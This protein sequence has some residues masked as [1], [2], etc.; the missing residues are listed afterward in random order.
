MKINLKK[1]KDYIDEKITNVKNTYQPKT[2]T[3]A[4]SKNVVT[5][6]NGKI[7]TEDKLTGSSTNSDIKISNYIAN[8]G[9]S[10]NF[11]KADHIHPTIRETI[12]SP[13]EG[14]PLSLDTYVDAGLYKI[15]NR[16]HTLTYNTENPSNENTLDMSNYSYGILE[17]KNY[18][19]ASLIQIIYL[20]KNNTDSPKIYYRKRYSKWSNWEQITNTNDINDVKTYVDNKISSTLTGISQGT[21]GA[22]EHTA[23][24]VKDSNANTYTNISSSLSNTSTQ[25]DINSAINT[26]ISSL[27]NIDLVKIVT[28]TNLPTASASTMNQL[29][30][31]T[32]TDGTTNDAYNIYV[33]VKNGSTY[34]WEKI[35]DFDLQLPTI[36]STVANNANHLITSKAVYDYA[37]PTLERGTYNSGDLNDT[38]FMQ[39][40]RYKLNCATADA[41]NNLPY[42]LKNLTNLYCTLEVR[43]Y[44]NNYMTQTL[45]AIKNDAKFP[46][47]FYRKK[48]G[49]SSDWDSEWREV[50]ENDGEIINASDTVNKQYLRLFRLQCLPTTSS[51]N[52]TIHLTF[53]LIDFK[54]GKSHAKIHITVRYTKTVTKPIISILECSDLTLL[55]NIY[56]CK[57]HDATNG[58]YIDIFLKLTTIT[59]LYTKIIDKNTPTGEIIQ[60][61][62]IKDG[63]ESYTW[64]N[65]N[66]YITDLNNAGATISNTSSFAYTEIKQGEYN[67]FVNK[68]SVDSGTSSQFLKA[69]G[70]ID[71]NDYIKTSSTS[72][73]IKND[74]TIGTPTNTTYSA[75]TNLYLNGTQFNHAASGVGTISNGL[76]KITIDTQGHITLA[77]P[78]TIDTAAANHANNLITSQAVYNGLNG[79]STVSVSP[80][81]T[82]GIEIGKITVDGTTKT[83]YQQDNNTT[84]TA[85]DGLKLSSGVFS[86]NP[87][88]TR[89]VHGTD[90]TNLSDITT[91]GWYN[92]GSDNS[93]L[94][95]DSP[96]TTAV[97]FALEVKRNNDT[98]NNYITQIIYTTP[99]TNT[100]PNAIYFRKISTSGSGTIGTNKSDWKQISTTD[101]THTISDLNPTTK[102]LLVYYTDGSNDT[103]NVVTK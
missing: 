61:K 37:Q 58:S 12:N 62:P 92:I 3:G 44:N 47:I 21:L 52:Q 24:Q 97:A 94:A 57:Y 16:N 34:S 69:D 2:I 14:D 86:V 33:T 40:G 67:L 93:T 72:G 28:T 31:K 71:E 9:T 38:T 30:L 70:S 63:N 53:E 48:V 79:K 23:A 32:K 18:S 88:P 68:I 11:A 45:Y 82:S 10:N 50:A 46:K 65:D 56:F 74:G 1:V 4:A 17:V 27:T 43:K 54:Y 95:A 91:P 22:H 64:T 77:N 81:K 73:Y 75:G 66:D 103:W 26:K 55:K 51:T 25:Q 8:A 78:V 7:T 35:D 98:N 19:N 15:D 41:I 20:I 89:L 101:H 59:G 76:Y 29:Y 96:L 90:F 13:S 60:Y 6:E 87:V 84:Y 39:Q 83:L 36:D 49:S 100:S 42:P 85:G 80:T 5:D 102:T 99:T